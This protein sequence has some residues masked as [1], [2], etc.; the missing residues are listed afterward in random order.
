MDTDVPSVESTVTPLEICD[1]F[2]CLNLVLVNNIAFFCVGRTEQH[3]HKSPLLKIHDSN[4]IWLIT[5][6]C[7]DIHNIYVTQ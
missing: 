7:I 1:E 5:C 6:H 3:C 2:I 4:Y